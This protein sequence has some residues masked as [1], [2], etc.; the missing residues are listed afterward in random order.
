MS[1]ASLVLGIFSMVC[2]PLAVTYVMAVL[3]FPLSQASYY[4]FPISLFATAISA[5]LAI[6]FS[7]ITLRKN[8]K[9]GR[10]ISGFT[11]GVVY[12]LLTTVFLVFS[13]WGPYVF[14]KNVLFQYFSGR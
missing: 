8:K 2:N 7:L 13:T 1:I 14:I 5:I 6:I 11:L 3:N 4:I 9:D 12:I 10:A